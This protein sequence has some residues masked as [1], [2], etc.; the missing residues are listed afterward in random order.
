MTRTRDHQVGLRRL[1]ESD[2]PGDSASLSTSSNYSGGWNVCAGGA[3]RENALSHHQGWW[4]RSPQT[5]TGRSGKG[6]VTAPGAENWPAG[7]LAMAVEGLREPG[8]RH[9]HFF[10]VAREAA[11]HTDDQEAVRQ[12]LRNIPLNGFS[13]SKHSEVET[14]IRSLVRDI[15][16]KKRET[17]I[18]GLFSGCPLGDKHSPETNQCRARTFG[19]TEGQGTLLQRALP[20]ALRDTR[21]A[22]PAGRHSVRPRFGLP[23]FGVAA[24]ERQ[25]RPVG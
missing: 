3:F 23:R 9:W 21:A 16:K 10:A 15:Y 8:S 20:T 2:T 5:P 7:T 4:L 24:R 25:A 11:I 6:T 18:A 13:D 12:M 22:H 19:V 14:D 17:G 1:P